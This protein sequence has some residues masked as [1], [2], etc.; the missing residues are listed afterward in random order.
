MTEWYKY[1]TCTSLDQ[2]LKVLLFWC[3]SCLKYIFQ[4]LLKGWCISQS[5]QVINKSKLFAHPLSKAQSPSCPCIKRGYFCITLQLPVTRACLNFMKQIY[6]TYVS[7]FYLEKKIKLKMIVLEVTV[8]FS[9][10]PVF[11]NKQITHRS[12]KISYR[13]ESS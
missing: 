1:I 3:M 12:V 6:V 2:I 10:Y 5:S 7:N 11:L 8:K 13:T 9:S 4:M